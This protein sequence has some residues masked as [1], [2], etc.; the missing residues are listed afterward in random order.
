MASH[1]I[2]VGG[3]AKPHNFS[4]CVERV[5]FSYSAVDNP[6]T[7]GD[8]YKLLALPENAIL[9]SLTIDLTAAEGAA[10]TVD[11]GIAAG[12]TLASTDGGT[13]GASTIST[14]NI[15]LNASL[16]NIVNWV[17]PIAIPAS[18]GIWMHADAAITAAEFDGVAVVIYPEV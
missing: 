6:A 8:D 15:A 2:S 14:G 9:L 5:P 1:D 7:S 17:K 11:F 10:D 3:S 13:G 18:G 4:A 16:G 12:G